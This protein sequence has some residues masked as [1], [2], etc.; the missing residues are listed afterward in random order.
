[1]LKEI[2]GADRDSKFQAGCFASWSTWYNTEIKIPVALF[3]INKVAVRK[4]HI[5]LLWSYVSAWMNWKICRELLSSCQPRTSPL[6]YTSPKALPFSGAT[7]RTWTTWRNV[8]TDSKV[9]ATYCRCPC[10]SI[11]INAILINNNMPTLRAIVDVLIIAFFCS[12][13][14]RPSF[15]FVILSQAESPADLSLLSIRLFVEA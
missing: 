5:A 12:P 14:H 13:T 11:R 1:M 15:T 7:H 9:F 8:F 6:R 4:V 3:A 10:L 2:S